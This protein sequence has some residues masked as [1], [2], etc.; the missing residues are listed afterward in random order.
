MIVNEKNE[1]PK[2]V[3][4]VVGTKIYLGVDEDIMLNLK[5]YERDF[6]VTL[7]CC[8]D[9]DCVLITNLAVYYVAQI[10][11]PARAYVN[12]VAVPFSMDNC[13]LDLWSMD[14]PVNVDAPVTEVI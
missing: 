7:N 6:E 4:R 12:S 5:N 1:G 3:Y 8:M 11:I 10:T 2:L 14:V 9:Y 13:I